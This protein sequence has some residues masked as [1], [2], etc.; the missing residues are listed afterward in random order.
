MN[1]RSAKCAV[2]TSSSPSC[3]GQDSESKFQPYFLVVEGRT[4]SPIPSSSSFLLT[5]LVTGVTFNL[6]MT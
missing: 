4:R 6:R 1:Y 3:R 5:R 2:S